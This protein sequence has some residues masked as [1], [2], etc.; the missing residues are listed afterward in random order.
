MTACSVACQSPR[1]AHRPRRLDGL[2][3]LLLLAWLLCRVKRHV[4]MVYGPWLADQPLPPNYFNQRQLVQE[5]VVDELGINAFVRHG[6]QLSPLDE[7]LVFW[8]P[9][10]RF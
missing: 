7:P 2:F 8:S 9:S 4:S 10:E 3:V 1:M 6:Q 5:G